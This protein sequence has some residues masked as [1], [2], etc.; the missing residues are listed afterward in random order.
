MNSE[1]PSMPNTPGMEGEAEAAGETIGN[2]KPGSAYSH[3]S[4]ARLPRCRT[5][6]ETLAW[7]YGGFPGQNAIP[8]I[9]TDLEP[10]RKV[11]RAFL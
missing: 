2:D 5:L 6:P 9:A 7:T 4:L 10:L 3:R 8:W 11:E 1:R